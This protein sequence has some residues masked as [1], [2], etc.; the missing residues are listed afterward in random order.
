MTEKNL[1]FLLQTSLELVPNF[2]KSIRKAR[3]GC[4]RAMRPERQESFAK[5]L[6]VLLLGVSLQ[7]DGAIC[8]INGSTVRPMT[9]EDMARKAGLN[10]ANIERMLADLKDMGY[11][12]SEQIKRKNR[13][14][15]QLEV[16]PGLRF[17][18]AKFWEDLGLKSL[19]E[20]SVLWAKK[21]C[22]RYLTMPFKI[23][24]LAEKKV[25]QIG[26]FVGNLL[27]DMHI[28]AEKEKAQNQ[29]MREGSE[30][31]KFWSNEILTMLRQRRK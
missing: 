30:R 1:P 2:I 3:P 29:E 20:K 18:T 10:T 4:V 13:V 19:F 27:K 24:K 31:A 7:H 6:P 15:G 9:V 16:S 12:A 26:G 8:I 21:H 17:F 28:A 22:K 14:N 23:V 25:K 5:F 11:I